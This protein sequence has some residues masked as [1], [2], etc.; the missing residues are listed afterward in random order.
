MF[1]Y[2]VGGSEAPNGGADWLIMGCDCPGRLILHDHGNG[3][4]PQPGG[5]AANVR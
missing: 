2:Q 5:A 4:G 3:A 1:V